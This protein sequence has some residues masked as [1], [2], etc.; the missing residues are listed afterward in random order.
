LLHKCK[1]EP[2][3]LLFSSLVNILSVLFIPCVLKAFYHR[4][5]RDR[6]SGQNYLH[7]D[8]G[9]HQGKSSFAAI[10][11]P[12]KGILFYS[13]HDQGAGPNFLEVLCFEASAPISAH[14]PK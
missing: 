8:Q 1:A 3:D 12:K 13:I 2:P 9:L 6:I 5:L 4:T 10:S 7:S 14:N 11:V